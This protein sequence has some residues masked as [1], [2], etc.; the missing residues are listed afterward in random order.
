M[1]VVDFA[2]RTGRWRI[3]PPTQRRFSTMDPSPCFLPPLNRRVLRKNMTVHGS[4]QVFRG[5]KRVGLH[6]SDF[7]GGGLVFMRVGG[8]LRG[9][10]RGC[11][12]RVEKVGLGWR[13]IGIGLGRPG[14]SQASPGFSCHWKNRQGGGIQPGI[15]KKSFGPCF[16]RSLRFRQCN[17]WLHTGSGG[18][19]LA[20]TFGPDRM[21]RKGS[22]RKPVDYTRKPADRDLMGFYG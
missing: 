19:Q 18:G 8:R 11:S 7:C 3:F 20:D 6:Y 4:S 9:E 1:A 12:S 14:R 10:N 21:G 16:H 13:S 2:K 17:P 15:L 5:V 22:E